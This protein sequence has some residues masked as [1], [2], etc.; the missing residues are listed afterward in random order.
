MGTDHHDQ[1]NHAAIKPARWA[2]FDKI[3]SHRQD[4]KPVHAQCLP[5][6]T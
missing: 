4:G 6:L 3:T 5:G 1:D 2:D